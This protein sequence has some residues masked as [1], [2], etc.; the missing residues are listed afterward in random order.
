MVMGFLAGLWAFRIKS[1]WCP[2]CGATTV[3]LADGDQ[4]PAPRPASRNPQ[5]SNHQ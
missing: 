5:G 4:V 1:R 3:R 2:A